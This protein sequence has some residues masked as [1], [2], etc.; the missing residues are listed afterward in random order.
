M[1]QT[2]SRLK[3]A[4]NTG[5]KTVMV[6]GVIGGSKVKYGSVGNIVSCTVKTANVGGVVKAHDKVWGV[7]VRTRKEVNR[8]DGNYIRFNDNAVVLINKASK[9]PLGTVVF[10]PVAREVKD[11]GFGKVASLAP[12]VL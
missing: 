7:I 10:G 1:V 3:V 12:E 9:E 2:Q 4:D 8:G 5:A 11:K 6:I